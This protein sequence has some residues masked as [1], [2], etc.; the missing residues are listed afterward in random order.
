MLPGASAV[1]ALS[2]HGA[3]DVRDLG[4]KGDGKIPV[5]RAQR[6]KTK[7]IVAAGTPSPH[8]IRVFQRM[9]S[10]SGSRSLRKMSV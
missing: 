8:P 6:L 5:T 9:L 7:P 3:F 1:V 4:A 10:R 2:T